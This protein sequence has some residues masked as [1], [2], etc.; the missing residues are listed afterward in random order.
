[1][2]TT[3]KRK[4]KK[5]SPDLDSDFSLVACLRNSLES[6][7][8]LN[9]PLVM[10]ANDITSEVT[11]SFAFVIE[12]ASLK[13]KLGVLLKSHYKYLLGIGQILCFEPKL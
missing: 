11:I 13:T 6:Y 1:M 7:L 10:L 3:S 5:F 2:C 12:N 8:M 9:P 4:L